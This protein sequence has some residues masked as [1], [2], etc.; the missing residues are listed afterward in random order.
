LLET[1]VQVLGFE[2]V[3]AQ[4]TGGHH[5][6]LR[7]YIDNPYGVSVDDCADVSHQLSAILDVEDP[8]SGSYSLEV[9]SPGLDRPLVKPADFERFAGEVIK[10][11][12]QQPIAGRRNFKGR[13]LG[14]TGDRVI[15]ET[16]GEQYDLA[17]ADIEKARLVPKL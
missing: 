7:V 11:R 14:L 5:V 1:G 13:L 8:F 17:L 2:L 12:L 15:L 16:D 4:V 6:V 10:V 3:D 9:S